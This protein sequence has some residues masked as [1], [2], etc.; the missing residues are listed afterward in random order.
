MSASFAAVEAR[1]NAAVVKHLANATA[2]IGGGVVV[3]GTYDAE[4]QEVL[5]VSAAQPAFLGAFT[6]MSALGRGSAV[7]ISCSA[8]SMVAV[9]YT[10][11][12]L[13]QEHGMTRLLLRRTA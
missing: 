12:E 9:P 8:L 1:I 7:A 2:D 6:A 4:Y 10:V 3:D 11:A 5:G 13:H